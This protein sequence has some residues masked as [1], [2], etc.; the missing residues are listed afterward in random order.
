MGLIAR[1]KAIWYALLNRSVTD[2]EDKH[3]IALAEAKLQQATATLRDAR[4]GL[5]TYQALVL[6]VQQQ[7]DNEMA[8]IQSLTGQIKNHL[9]ANQEEMAAQLAMELAQVKADLASNQEQL[10]QHEQNYENNLLK[11]KSA[12]SDID[13]AKKD[14]QKKKAELQMEKALAEV[15]ETAGALNANLDV[16]SDIGQ[17][18][19]RVDDQIHKA[20][21]RSRVASDLGDKDIAVLKA[22]QEAERVQGQ[23]LLEQF[24]IEEGL[25]EAPTAQAEKTVGPEQTRERRAETESEGS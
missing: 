21:A 22:K 20:K 18:L 16:S 19:S 10:G 7:V 14:L 23:E 9:K 11:M 13:N 6:K 24:K 5:I 4:Q 1:I 12:L 2:M 3:V 25:A 15:S 8:R 17:I